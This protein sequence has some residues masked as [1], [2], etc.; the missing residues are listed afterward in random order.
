MMFRKI[1]PIDIVGLKFGRWFVANLCEEKNDNGSYQYNCIC[2]CGTSSLVSRASLS[3]KRSQSCGCLQRELRKQQGATHTCNP[4]DIVGETFG[5]LKVQGLNAQRGKRNQYQYLCVCDCG[6]FKNVER[7][8][9]VA[10]RT[11]SCGCLVTCDAINLIGKKL[12]RWTVQ[13]LAGKNEYG[14][15]Q[16]ICV[17]D[18]GVQRV[19]ERG[20][21]ISG[22]S[23]SCGCLARELTRQRYENL[24]YTDVVGKTFGR[25]TVLK[26]AEKYVGKNRLFV[27]ECECGQ[28]TLVQKAKLLNGDTKSCGCLAQERTTKYFQEYRDEF[29]YTSC[30]GLVFGRWTLV[31]YLDHK[32]SYGHCFKCRCSCGTIAESIGWYSLTKGQSRS[33]GCIRT[34]FYHSLSNQE[35]RIMNRRQRI[36]FSKSEIRTKALGRDNQRCFLCDRQDQW[37]EI[38]H[39]DPWKTNELSRFELKNL[40]SLCWD[41]HFLAHNESFHGEVD[42]VLTEKFKAYTA[43]FELAEVVNA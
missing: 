36:K 9:L 11:R 26:I 12:A 31:K 16:Y 34:E 15:Y 22:G 25:L 17:C 33:C 2:D 7:D 37:L 6:S 32:S 35:E 3:S 27:C 10:G 40:I 42:P 14:N 28:K 24:D 39:I 41:C 1:N 13:D 43:Q 20:N 18:C 8:N 5:R 23:Q 4:L 30:I 29:D 21:L 19:V 38:H